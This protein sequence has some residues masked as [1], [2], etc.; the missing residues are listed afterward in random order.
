MKS[1]DPEKTIKRL[2]FWPPLFAIMLLLLVSCVFAYSLQIS[3]AENN[4]S[5]PVVLRHLEGP[6]YYKCQV[7]KIVDGD[8]I[9]VRFNVWVDIILEKRIRFENIDTWEVRGEEKEKG[10]AAKA[11]LEKVLAQGGVYLRTDGKT[12]KYGRTIGSMWIIK[13]GVKTNVADEL[14]KNGHEKIKPEL[15]K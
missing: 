12:G 3:A 10:L 15:D 9:D 6:R 8:T 7:I 4:V 2:K 13:D 14:I 11:F 5:S 1:Y